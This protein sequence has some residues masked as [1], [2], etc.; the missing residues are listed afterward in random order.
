[1]DLFDHH[2]NAQVEAEAPLAARMRPRTLDEFIGQD[3]VVGPGR[4]LRRAIQADQLSSLIFY[5]PPGTGKTTLAQIIANSTSAQFLA[6]NAVLAGVKD[7]RAAIAQAQ[8]L[9]GQFGRRTI[10]FID[11]VHRF[12]KAQQD[13]LL[14]WVENGTVILIGA[15]TENP[16]FEVNKALVSRSRIFQL[17]SLEQTDLYRVAEQALADPVR[18]YGARSVQMH[19][20]ALAHLVKVANGDA[21]ALLNALELAV[22]TTE[23]D[24]TGTLHITLTVAEE[25]IQQ[26]A[27]LYDKEGDAHFD[28]IS[29]F[30]KSVR[31]SDP[32]AALYWLARM[33]YAGEDPRFI[34]RRLVILA[35]EDV[36]LADPQAVTIVTSCAAALDRA[37]MPEGRYPLAQ[38]TLYLATAPKSNSTMAFFDALSAV[39]KEQQQDIPNP[40][41]DANRDKQG[42]GHG[43]GYLYPHSYREHWVAQQYLPAGLQ[44]RVFYQPSEQGYESS[45]RLQV[46]RR[47]EA[48]LAAMVEG[49]STPTLEALTYSPA[50]P[51]RDRW[52]Q[53]TL[54]QTGAQLGQLRDRLFA[55]LP[56]QRHHLVLDLNARSGLLTWEAVRQ[57]PEGRVFA[58]VETDEDFAALTEQAALL[59]ELNRPVVF[60]S[61]LEDLPDALATIAAGVAVEAVVG[62]HVFSAIAP[63]PDLIQ[64]LVS[65]V[66]PQ[67]GRLA[68]VEA[69]P[70]NAQRIGALVPAD[71]LDSQLR[72]RWKEA[73]EHLYTNAADP[74]FG[75]DSKTLVTQLEKAGLMVNWADEVIEGERF[76][77][78]KLCDRWFAPNPSTSYRSKLAAILS[79]QELT[80]IEKLVRRSLQNQT[81][82]W[83]SHQV[84]LWGDRQSARSAL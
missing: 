22:E 43:Q 40:L 11:E 38:A 46:E 26:R 70:R 7:I 66:A 81:V 49:S 79:P 31:G 76:I 44:G 37:G 48:Q 63:T 3:A 61:A 27:V 59:P 32:D 75:W 57:V 69:I 55:S 51:A 33:I 39:E 68:L 17:K 50:D 16:F 18:G 83:R 56:L 9:R 84:W 12:N 62:R 1:M 77:S 58:R 35:S 13:A 67:Q 28:T 52:L 73:E 64:T 82:T 5:G 54:S 41:R 60:Q 29:A 45:I 4:L 8:E 14:P 10:L 23:P 42:F 19:E 80:E 71:S 25:S 2:R 6:L 24:R 34:F 36:G 21:R 74:R 78:E 53:R 30:I 65:C 47:R 72:D 20:E 15:T